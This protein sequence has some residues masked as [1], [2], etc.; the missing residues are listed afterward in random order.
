MDVLKARENLKLLD[1]ELRLKMEVQVPKDLLSNLSYERF[2]LGYFCLSFHSNARSSYSK[3]FSD[4]IIRIYIT[5]SYSDD[6]MDDVTATLAYEY[7]N[8][9]QVRKLSEVTTTF[10]KLIKAL[11]LWFKV[12][13]TELKDLKEVASKVGTN[14]LCTNLLSTGQFLFINN[15]LYEKIDLCV[16]LEKLGFG[17]YS[18]YLYNELLGE[19]ITEASFNLTQKKEAEKLF[20]SLYNDSELYY[21][22]KYGNRLI[23]KGV[24]TGRPPVGV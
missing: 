4:T 15:T 22:C 2:Q 5:L 3:K 21:S 24:K 6:T 11:N 18:V 16:H 13:I 23:R 14:D 12:N 9:D 8:A 17:R 19:V 20:N 7:H 10:S 1:L